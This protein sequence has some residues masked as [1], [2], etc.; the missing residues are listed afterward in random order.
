M[1]KSHGCVDWSRSAGQICDQVRAFKP[2]PGTYSFWKDNSGKSHRLILDRV[3][4]A[5]EAETGTSTPG[6]VIDHPE[7]HLLLG[8][9]DGLLAIDTVQPAGKRVMSAEEYLRGH[10][11]PAGTIFGS[12]KQ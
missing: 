8:T 3:H 4:R 6:Q 2:W 1:T 11:I 12:E 5:E 10:P 9:G 7:T